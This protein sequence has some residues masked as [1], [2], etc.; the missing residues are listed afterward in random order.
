MLCELVF[1]DHILSL[2][3]L[4]QH[5]PRVTQLLA[6]A[7]A[8]TLEPLPCNAPNG[9][10][11]TEGTF[12]SETD[13]AATG[14]MCVGAPRRPPGCVLCVTTKALHSKEQPCVCGYRAKG[15]CRGMVS[16]VEHVAIAV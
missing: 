1:G 15:H 11:C 16:A 4:T 6:I 13:P 8:V 2:S 14:A 12:C 10:E 3:T 7:A 9:E 5:Q